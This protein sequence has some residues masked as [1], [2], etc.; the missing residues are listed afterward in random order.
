VGPLIFIFIFISVRFCG[1]IWYI[2]YG[3]NV[4][5]FFFFFKK[6]F[7]FFLKLKFKYQKKKKKKK[8]KKKR[9]IV[10]M[11]GKCRVW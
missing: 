6:L 3:R 4:L 9:E 1:N 2:C 11:F 8:K 10:G 5:F 7:K